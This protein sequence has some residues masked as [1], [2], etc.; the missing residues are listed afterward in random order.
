VLRACLRLLRPAGRTAFHT[1]HLAEGLTRAQHRRGARAGPVAVACSRPHTQ[2]LGAAGF[3]DVRETDLTPE[4][5]SVTRA[6]MESYDA[7]RPE[8]EALLGRDTFVARQAERRS[9]L[10]AIEAGLLRR[11][12]LV[13]SRP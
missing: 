13:A 8:L 12:M 7:H 2:L 5:A 3:V 11:S 4:F 6:W 9:Q 10:G 1:I